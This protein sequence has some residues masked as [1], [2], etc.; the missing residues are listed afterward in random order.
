[1]EKSKGL[2]LQLLHPTDK[3][4]ANIVL[5]YDE[6]QIYNDFCTLIDKLKIIKSATKLFVYD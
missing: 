1:M 4:T 6:K 5:K 3:N 2:Q